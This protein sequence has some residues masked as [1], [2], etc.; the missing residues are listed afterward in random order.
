MC[1]RDTYYLDLSDKPSYLLNMETG[2]GWTLDDRYYSIQKFGG[3]YLA[4]GRNGFIV[5]DVNGSLDV[6]K[7]QLMRYAGFYARQEGEQLHLVSG[8]VTRRDVLIDTGKITT[9]EL[10][11]TLFMKLFRLRT[12]TITAAGYGREWVDPRDAQIPEI[13]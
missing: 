11:Q 12:A 2:E 7:R 3:Y 4:D 9:L 8:L 1:I 10:R 5:F 13:Q 6:Y